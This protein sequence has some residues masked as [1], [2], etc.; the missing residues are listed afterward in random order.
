ME[1]A[2]C[3]FRNLE[4]ISSAH[5]KSACSHQLTF[6][7]DCSQDPY[8][9]ITGGNLTGFELIVSGSGKQQGLSQSMGI[10]IV[11]FDKLDSHDRVGEKCL[12]LFIHLF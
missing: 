10:T 8:F 7:L 3:I 1:K 6:C 11:G 12:Y 9:D 5:K 4:F 2:V